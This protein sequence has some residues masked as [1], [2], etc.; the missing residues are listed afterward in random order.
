MALLILLLTIIVLDLAA[1]RWGVDSTDG[2]HSLEWMRRQLW[3]GF[4]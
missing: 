3:Y 4:H 2:I 1:Q